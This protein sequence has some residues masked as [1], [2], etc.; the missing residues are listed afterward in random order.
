VLISPRGTARATQATADGV[1]RVTV[2]V[3]NPAAQTEVTPPAP[4][5]APPTATEAL[6]PIAAPKP[7]IQAIA[8]DPGHG[9]D[10]AG[11]HGA[12]GTAEKVVTLDI[13]RRLK[14]LIETR[15]GVRVIL[16]REDDHA[17][18]LDERAAI[19]NNGKADLFLSL[20]MNA[21]LAPAVAGAEVF[22]L[23]LTREA[24]DVRLQATA[25]EVTLPVLGG[26]TRPID[27]IPWDLAQ[28]RH[29]DA[30][31]T[32]AAKLEEQLRKHVPMG[33][34]PLQQ[35][36][37]RVL[38]AV[39]MPAALVEMAYLTNAAQERA[40]QSGDFPATVAQALFDAIVSF[41]DTLGDRP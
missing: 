14:M 19:A 35:A 28:V 1:T 34:R 20:H 12:G 31:V 11:A 26:G 24:Q 33:P 15:L 21:A 16:T 4:A 2:D 40:F 13:A 32:F 38:G 7:A 39:N 25:Q 36:P 10:D 27:I 3:I 18:G 29:V 30:S 23:K 37:M 22:A 5:P 8:I 9:G 6:P 41:R 17:V